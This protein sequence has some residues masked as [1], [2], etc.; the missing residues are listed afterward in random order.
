MSLC[1]SVWVCLGVCLSVCLPVQVSYLAFTIL[2]HCL[3]TQSVQQANNLISTIE[4]YPLVSTQYAHTHTHIA[5]ARPYLH[6]H[7]VTSQ[8]QSQTFTA[9]VK[10]LL[11]AIE[12]TSL[13][14][15][16]LSDHTQGNEKSSELPK[17]VDPS[18][19]VV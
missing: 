13:L 4:Q 17:A 1:L 10:M 11:N 5:R 12:N 19:F 6:Q 14:P 2:H 8:T 9:S 18:R 16:T 15:L 7:N 3:P